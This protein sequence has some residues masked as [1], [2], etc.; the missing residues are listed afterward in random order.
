M[1]INFTGDSFCY[2]GGQDDD[3]PYSDIAW[4]TLLAD[5]LGASIVGL[6]RSGSSH[7]HVFKTF[8]SS[9]D[10]NVICWTEPQRL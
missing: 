10:I 9:A 3:R 7:E 8:N 1:R 2:K 5:R 6:G 4:T